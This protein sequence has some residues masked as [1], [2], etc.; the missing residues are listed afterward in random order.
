MAD[1][2]R[3]KRWTTYFT[4]GRSSASYSTKDKSVAIAVI[5]GYEPAKIE[6]ESQFMNVDDVIL[7]IAKHIR[8]TRKTKRHA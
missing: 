8:A 2:L 7:D 1:I 3:L 4:D 6:D 5:V